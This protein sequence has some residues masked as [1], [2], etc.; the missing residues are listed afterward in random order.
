MLSMHGDLSWSPQHSQKG[1]SGCTCLRHQHW[2]ERGWEGNTEKQTRER[3]RQNQKETLFPQ[4]RRWRT[5]YPRVSSGLMASVGPH[6]CTCNART[7]THTHAHTKRNGSRH[8]IWGRGSCFLSNTSTELGSKVH[9]NYKADKQGHAMTSLVH[10]PDWLMA[11]N[12][13]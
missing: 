9:P 10:L 5:E 8:C 7:R 2:R 3:Q 6:T 13:V 12:T 11:Q 1:S 4:E